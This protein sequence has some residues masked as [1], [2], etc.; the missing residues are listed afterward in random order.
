MPAAEKKP[1]WTCPQCG[2]K[3]VTR[4][5]WHSCGMFTI[6]ALFEKCEPSVRTTFDALQ[7]HVKAIAKDVLVVAQKTRA[8]FQLRTRFISVYP[9]KDHVL[10]GF[11]FTER[12]RD[13]RFTKIE[14]PIT[15]AFIHYARLKAPSDVDA[16]V[17]AWI[18]ASLPYGRQE[19]ALGMR[20][21]AST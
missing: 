6:D 17:D 10:A 2:A 11:I 18:K 5:M 15:G 16:I 13:E 8:V 19:R 9:R 3:L 1:L 12:V 7:R 14:G 20:R 4:N 21:T